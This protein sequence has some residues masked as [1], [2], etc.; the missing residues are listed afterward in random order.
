[1][2]HLNNQPIVATPAKSLWQYFVEAYT[3]NYFNFKGR[4]RRREYWGIWLFYNLIALAIS[5]IGRL[6]SDTDA[7]VFSMLSSMNLTWIV[8]SV[9]W[10]IISFFPQASAIVRR[11]HDKG[12]SG[13]W[14]LGVLFSGL[15]FVTLS[16]FV[17][18]SLLASKGQSNGLLV[19][20]GIIGLIFIV[21]G[22]FIFI[23]LLLDGDKTENKYGPSP[24]YMHIDEYVAGNNPL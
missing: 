3:Q 14:Y 15:I 2:E 24:K 10:S 8:I 19:L 5:V 21:L 22:I 20:F 11:L 16:L 1:M 6:L 13:K 4:A 18:I 23:L 12:Y 7:G 17:G 9:L